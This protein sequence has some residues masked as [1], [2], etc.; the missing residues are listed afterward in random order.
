MICG[1]YLV[2]ILA[3]GND[4][5][6]QDTKAT[7]RKCLCHN[8]LRNSRNDTKGGVY[9]SS[10]VPPITSEQAAYRLLRLFFKSQSALI[11]LLLL[12]KSNPL[13]WASIWFWAQSRKKIDFAALVHVGAKSAPLRFKAVPFGDRLKTALR[14]FAPPFQLEPAALGFELVGGA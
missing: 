6:R 12:S 3:K 8:G 2:V 14:S 5:W 4:Q 10:P 13:R 9:F 11:A 7:T 1:H